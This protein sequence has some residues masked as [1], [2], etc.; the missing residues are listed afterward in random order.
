MF[1]DTDIYM[2]N[3]FLSV[4]FLKSVSKP[5]YI[6]SVTKSEKFEVFKPLVLLNEQSKTQ[7]FPFYKHK[8]RKIEIVHIWKARTSKVAAV[9]LQNILKH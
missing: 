6:F 2:L 5:Y 8:T 9:L 3:K 1:T 7:I 4:D